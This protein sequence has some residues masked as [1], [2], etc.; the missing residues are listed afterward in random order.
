[1]N[2]GVLQQVRSACADVVA[3]ARFV[4][5][6]VDRIA[7]YARGLPLE[8]VRRPE[9]DAPTHYV[10]H[11]ADTVAFFVTLDAINFGSGYFPFMH[12][13]PGMSGYFTVASSLKDRFEREGPFNADQL[14][15]L[16]VEECA[17]IFGQDLQSPPMR[18]LMGLFVASLNDLG[19]F[20]NRRFGGSFTALIEDANY[21]VERLAASLIEMPSFQDVA[22]YH[23]RDVPL[24]KRAQI[25]AADIE[26]AFRGEGWGRFD[27]LD[28]LTIYADNLVP[29][30]LRVDG[31]LRYAP[32]L[33]EQIERGDLIPAGSEE[34]TEM[35][36]CAIHAVEL[37]VAAL[38][39]HEPPVYAMHLDFLLWNRGQEARYKAAPRHRTRTIF[40]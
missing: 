35:R 23:G 34:E 16:T 9:H 27:D 24:Y 29:H 2:Q 6:E 19:D 15:A 1:M 12:K 14:A 21:S 5:V 4:H 13:R 18:E 40:Y 10:E 26:I 17:A 39:G 20:L 38:R 28:R 31:V 25:T 32:E 37:M 8:Q 7:E 3:Q 30:V 22:R 11:G 33:L 36:A